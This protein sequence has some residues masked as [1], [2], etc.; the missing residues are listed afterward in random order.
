MELRKPQVLAVGLT[1]ALYF[2]A[3]QIF[4]FIWTP[5]LQE[6]SGVKMI[7][8]GMIFM[9]MM[10]SALCQ[11]KLLGILHKLLKIEYFTINILYLIAF[12]L[13]FLTLKLSDS[14]LLSLLTL[15]IINGSF[16][17]Y[18]PVLG[19]M[20]SVLL[21]EKNRAFMMNIFKIPLNIIVILLLTLSSYFNPQYI[22]LFSSILLLV[23]ILCGFFLKNYF[24][25]NK[26]DIG[27]K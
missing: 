1:D 23:A 16:G 26:D 6:N 9:L 7:N 19:Y 25:N 10:L 11:N 22:A 15:T 8:T 5:I 20:R 17:M 2:S 21:A 14:F 24:E 4:M 12:C 13:C 18:V 27:V 3:I